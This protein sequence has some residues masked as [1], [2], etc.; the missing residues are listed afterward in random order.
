LAEAG[1]Q[2]ELDRLEVEHIAKARAEEVRLVNMSDGGGG[3]AGYVTPPEVRAKL[4]ASNLGKPHPKHTPEWKTVMSERMTGRSIHTDASKDAIAASKRG[5]PRSPEVKAKLSAAMKGRPSPMKG[6]EHSDEAKARNSRHR[7]GKHAG[8]QH[9]RFRDDV[10]V[11]V[12]LRLLSEGFPKTDV[13]KILGTSRAVVYKRI[14]EAKMQGLMIPTPPRRAWNKGKKHS[15]EHLNNW[16]ASR[17]GEK[18]A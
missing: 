9:H 14:R 15:S 7:K 17:W 1:D 2:K 10:T 8:A 3:R 16:I 6:R 12:V 5:V 13:A 18:A 11:E 4:R